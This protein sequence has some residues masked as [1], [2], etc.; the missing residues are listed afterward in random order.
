[1]ATL[2]TSCAIATRRWKLEYYFEEGIG[3]LFD[4]ACDPLERNDLFGDPDSRET[5]QALVEALLC[6]RSQIADVNGLIQRTTADPN[7]MRPGRRY[8]IVAPRIAAHTRAM[9]GS[10]A[11]ER[12]GEKAEKCDGSA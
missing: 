6:W 12:L 7:A 5:R 8:T 10:D 4:R 3:R 11:E 1:M 9:R 2:Y